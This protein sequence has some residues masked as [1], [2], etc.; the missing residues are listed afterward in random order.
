[1]LALLSNPVGGA[2]YLYKDLCASLS[3]ICDTQILEPTDFLTNKSCSITDINHRFLHTIPLEKYN[4]FICIGFSA[5]GFFSS[6]MGTELYNRNLSVYLINLDSY[7]MLKGFMDD[8]HSPQVSTLYWNNVWINSGKTSPFRKSNADQNIM[9]PDLENEDF[10]RSLLKQSDL[11]EPYNIYEYH[12]DK[13]QKNHWLHQKLKETILEKI[14][15]PTY[16]ISSQQYISKF[17][18]I[19]HQDNIYFSKLEDIRIF[20]V[21]H[22]EFMFTPSVLR[23]LTSLISTLKSI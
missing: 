10:I 14:S 3:N 2:N 13:L 1:M 23:Y 17:D 19:I 7:P 20:D 5:G 9:A 4:K 12:Q 16:M 11:P 6:L 8:F 21:K 22:E 18:A 15:I